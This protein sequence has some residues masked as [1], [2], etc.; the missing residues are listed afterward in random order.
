MRWLLVILILFPEI[1]NAECAWVLWM[2]KAQRDLNVY[3]EWS[4]STVFDTKNECIDEMNRTANIFKSGKTQTIKP[5]VKSDKNRKNVVTVEWFD[6]IEP[7]KTMSFQIEC[8]P[9]E[10]K[11]K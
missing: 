8:W 3:W 11:P 7:L 6:L 5:S 9:S 2:R 10:I 4:P 1:V